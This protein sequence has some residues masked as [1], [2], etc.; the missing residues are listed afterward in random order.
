MHLFEVLEEIIARLFKQVYEIRNT[1]E[2][3]YGH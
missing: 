1:N 2:V 3:I